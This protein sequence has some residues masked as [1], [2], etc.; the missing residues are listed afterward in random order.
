MIGCAIGFIT[1]CMNDAKFPKFFNYHRIT[2]H[3]TLCTKV[4]RYEHKMKVVLKIANSIRA[5]TLKS[6]V[7]SLK[8]RAAVAFHRVLGL[9]PVEAP[10][11]SISCMW[12]EE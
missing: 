4:L 8:Y 11:R 5:R 6:T 1:L 7:Q 10:T 2:H 12:E 3:Q 9:L